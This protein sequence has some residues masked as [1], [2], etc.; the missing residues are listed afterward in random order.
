LKIFTSV[1]REMIRY[2][3]TKNPVFQIYLTEL[4]ILHNYLLC[5][6]RMTDDSK[7]LIGS[8]NFK[9]MRF[10]WL[11]SRILLF[12]L[13]YLMFLPCLCTYCVHILTCRV[14]VF[15]TTFNNISVIS[16]VLVEESWAP[17]ENYWPAASAKTQIVIFYFL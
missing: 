16:V 6:S 11:Y 12:F 8:M 13:S 1:D 5:W 3:W 2:W 4:S 15:S 14:M 7:F 17:R 10:N 9:I